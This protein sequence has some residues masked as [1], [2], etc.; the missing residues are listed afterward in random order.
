MPV[1]QISTRS[2]PQHTTS[3]PLKLESNAASTKYI[4]RSLQEEMGE[5]KADDRGSIQKII[6]D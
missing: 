2:C 5:R 1:E 3:T 6:I 4:F